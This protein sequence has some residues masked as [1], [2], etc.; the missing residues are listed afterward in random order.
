MAQFLELITPPGLGLPNYNLTTLGLVFN[1][2]KEALLDIFQPITLVDYQPENHAIKVQMINLGVFGFP[3]EHSQSALLPSFFLKYMDDFADK[4]TLWSLISVTVDIALTFTGLSGLSILKNMRHVGKLGKLFRLNNVG[5]ASA[6]ALQQLGTIAR[7]RYGFTIFEFSASFCHLLL[8]Y[9]TANC[10]NF[11][12]EQTQWINAQWAQQNSQQNKVISGL[13]E[14]E[15]VNANSPVSERLYELCRALDDILQILS[16]VGFVGDISLG[17]A[18]SK[19]LKRIK[20]E[21]LIPDEFVNPSHANFNSQLYQIK[22][23][24]ELFNTAIDGVYS[25]F[26]GLLPNGQSK[27]TL[28][29]YLQS[30]NFTEIKRMHFI[31]DMQPLLKQFNNK[32]DDLLEF[33]VSNKHNWDSLYENGLTIQRQSKNILS[34]SFHVLGY[35]NAKD[36]GMAYTRLMKYSEAKQLD[37]IKTMGGHLTPL[38]WVKFNGSDD[39][40]KGFFRYFDDLE[41]RTE[42]KALLGTNG[43]DQAKMIKFLE[44]YGD[45]SNVAFRN[46]KAKAAKVSLKQKFKY[47]LDFP[48]ATHDIAYFN[49]RRAEIL[50]PGFEDVAK[51]KFYGAQ[52]VDSFIE[53]ELLTGG[54]ARPSQINDAGDIIMD[55]GSLHGLSLDP[56]GP[57]HNIGELLVGGL[58]YSKWL[59][60]INGERGFLP[61]IKRHFEKISNPMNGKPALDKVVIDYTYFEDISLAIGQNPNY[62][63]N[64]IDNILSNHF[65]VYNNSNFLIKLNY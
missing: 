38:E 19:K 63:K 48:N 17:I 3:E 18:M 41:L 62:F 15:D 50:P 37:F 40:F 42:F 31:E 9:T 5:G 46:L 2:K 49:K 6:A 35:I 8:Q 51:Q 43:T 13:P 30:S 22:N 59:D 39:L 26:V 29:N 32:Y 45:I 20:Q 1:E 57:P 34:N 65:P 54:K 27:T 61:S 36:Y 23:D 4:E 24:I 28:L 56:L 12:N 25:N 14:N 11:K 60:E 21:E 58:D 47:L 55:G 16:L 64:F 10:N 44:R 53:L 33:I 7:I 52:E